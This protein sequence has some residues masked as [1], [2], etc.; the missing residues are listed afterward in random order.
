MKVFEHIKKAIRRRDQLEGGY[1]IPDSEPVAL[2][3]GI[4]RPLTIQEQIKQMIRHEASMAAQENGHET[5]EEANDFDVDDEID[6]ISGYEVT[7]MV[8]EMPVAEE[9][10]L[11]V[12]PT[13]GS[14]PEDNPTP[15]Q[16]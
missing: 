10:P 11:P 2:R 3:P 14:M 13:E 6:P 9:A 4:K 1:E 7:Y 16:T 15:E 8:D 12:S 5:F